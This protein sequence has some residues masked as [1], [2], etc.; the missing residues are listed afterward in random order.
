VAQAS[1]LSPNPR[2][3]YLLWDEYENGIGGRKAETII[4]HLNKEARNKEWFKYDTTCMYGG[5]ITNNTGLPDHVSAA[6]ADYDAALLFVD[7]FYN[8]TVDYIDLFHSLEYDL[9]TSSYCPAFS[10]NYTCCMP[11]TC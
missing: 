5:D 4:E 2:T 8:E 6:L 10:C 3:L 1:T 9:P 7:M 11:G